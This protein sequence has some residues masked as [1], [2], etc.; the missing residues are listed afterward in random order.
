MDAV[1]HRSNGPGR[2][3]A[4]HGGERAGTKR[5]RRRAAALRR[6]ERGKFPAAI[7]SGVSATCSGGARAHA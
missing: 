5:M 2:V 7:S 4:G 6:R 1:D 3:Q